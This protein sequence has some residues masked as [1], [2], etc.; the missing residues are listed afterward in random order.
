IAKL[1]P[2]HP[3]TSQL[4]AEAAFDAVRAAGLPGATVQ[5]LYQLPSELGLKLV[6]AEEVGAIAFTGSRTAGLALKAAA[7]AAGK[8]IYLEMS[9]IN[10]IFLLPGAV[11]A[12]G[13]ELAKELFGSC[14][15]GAGQF[16]TNPGMSVV[17]ASPESEALVEELRKLFAQTPP[18]PLL[19]QQGPKNIRDSIAVL[20]LNGAQCLAGGQEAV[21]GPFGFQNTLLRVSG[22]QF[23]QAPEALQTEAFGTVHLMVFA[24]SMEQMIQIAHGLEGNLTGCIYSDPA[25]QDDAAYNQLARVLRYKVGRLLNDKVPTGVAVSPAMHHG[26]PYPSTGHPGFTAVGMPA[27]IKRFCARHCYD[28]VRPHRLPD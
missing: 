17:L 1:H 3:K 28:G 13:T 15:L 23:L 7:D 21:D 24:D 14:A 10:P 18:G 16:C 4:L 8:P 22:E 6:A 26:G 5:A 20:T 11:A 19:S 9:S 12:G 2:S 25:G 27:A